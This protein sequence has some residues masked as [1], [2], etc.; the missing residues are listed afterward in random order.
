MGLDIL[1]AETAGQLGYLLETELANALPGGPLVVSLLTQTV[2]DPADPAFEKPT[3]QIGPHYS[4][5]ARHRPPAC[6]S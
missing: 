3:K 1:D 5:E 6:W 4:K 2:V